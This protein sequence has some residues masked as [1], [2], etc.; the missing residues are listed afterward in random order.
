M[1]NVVSLSLDPNSSFDTDFFS[2]ASQSSTPPTPLTRGD[3]A[4][5]G[6]WNNKNGQAVINTVTGTPTLANWL[7]TNFSSLF[8][9]FGGQTNA[10]VAADFGTAFGNVGGVQG[11]TFA[12]AFAVG[13]ACY[14]TS[15]SLGG[16]SLVG[17]GLAAKY[18]FN[19]SLAGTCGKTYNVGN[20]GAAFG[21]PNNTS[22]TVLQIL[23]VANANFNPATGLFYGGNPSLTSSLNN[24][25]NGINQ[26][27]DIG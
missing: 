26:S 13:L 15:T 25:L 17:S 16:N 2:I 19:V 6:F 27:G 12:Q 1:T 10:Q 23:S 18:G 8:G 22:L 5:I 14:V 11:N 4:T 3:A 20:N 24:V 21:V 9:S 7:A